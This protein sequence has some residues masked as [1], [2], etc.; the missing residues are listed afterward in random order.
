M[1]K[2]EIWT[3]SKSVDKS[4][5]WISSQSY[6][7]SIEV[8]NKFEMEILYEMLR[9]VDNGSMMKLRADFQLGLKNKICQRLTLLEF[10]DPRADT[11][12]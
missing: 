3:D 8:V 1:D 5:I 7:Q 9:K 12:R 10:L 4:E 6:G 11:I 2:S